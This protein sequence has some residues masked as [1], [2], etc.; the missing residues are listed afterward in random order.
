M[1]IPDDFPRTHAIARLPGVQPKLAVRMDVVSGLYV[2]GATDDEVQVRYEVCSDLAAQLV[3]KCQSNR[4]TKYANLSEAQILERLL[5]QLLGTDWG[6]PPEMRW[7][8]RRTASE[9]QWTI[10]LD[11]CA[12][13][14]MLGD[15]E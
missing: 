9:L 2:S 6:T 13:R 14:V 7:I 4:D 15:L 10:P 3:A 8:I 5:A 1:P 11:A 12:L